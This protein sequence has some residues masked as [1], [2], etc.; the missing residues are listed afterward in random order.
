[1][2]Y[3]IAT[4]IIILGFLGGWEEVQQLVQRGNWL[5]KDYRYPEWFTDA[6]TW[7]KNLDSHHVAYGAFILAMCFAISLTY[8][9]WY[10][11]PLYW[12]G[13]FYVR[14]I[15]LHIIFKKKP[16]WKYLLP[17]L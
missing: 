12:V 6:K 13:V 5:R 16:L 4:S 11:A 15:T 7:K 1:M 10:F 17:L 8:F 3:L 14:N 9:A 2:I